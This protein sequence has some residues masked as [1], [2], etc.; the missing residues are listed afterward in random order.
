MKTQAQTVAEY[1]IPI[2]D[3]HAARSAS[4]KSNDLTAI[5]FLRQIR[6]QEQ[7]VVDAAEYERFRAWKASQVEEQHHG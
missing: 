3:K 4:E 7:Y 2:V 1:I 6:D 5:E